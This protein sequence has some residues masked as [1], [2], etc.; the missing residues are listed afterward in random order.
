M[1]ASM[2]GLTLDV[3]AEEFVLGFISDDPWVKSLI[4]KVDGA[5]T[6]WPEAPVIEFADPTVEDWVATLSDH[7]DDEDVVTVDAVATWTKD[8]DDIN[9]LAAAEDKKIR[10]VVAGRTWFAGR[11]VKNA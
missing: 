10:F 7:T 4:Y 1:L 8:E 6:A 2:A 3:T 9:L 11:A 5:P